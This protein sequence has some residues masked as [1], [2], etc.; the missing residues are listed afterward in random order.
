M[1]ITAIILTGKHQKLTSESGIFR[2][3]KLARGSP[4]WKNMFSLTIRRRNDTYS[5]SERTSTLSE[6]QKL[7]VTRNGGFLS[8]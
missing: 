6:S 2:L 5:R 4:L 7:D 3:A 1:A 8:P